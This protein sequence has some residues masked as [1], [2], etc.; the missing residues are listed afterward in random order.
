MAKSE[1]FKPPYLP[2]MGADSPHSKTVFL[3]AP[4]AITITSPIGGRAPTRGQTRKVGVGRKIS[5]PDFSN[6]NSGIL[7]KLAEQLEDHVHLHLRR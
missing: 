7:I 4:R 1:I 2:Q 5:N 3:R 6:L